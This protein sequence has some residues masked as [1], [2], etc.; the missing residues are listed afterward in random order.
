MLYLI[1]ALDNNRE[2]EPWV[3]VTVLRYTLQKNVFFLFCVFLFSL[4]IF[5]KTGV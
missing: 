2:N 4:W 1:P 5:S 3:H